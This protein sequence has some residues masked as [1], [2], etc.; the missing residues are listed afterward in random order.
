MSFYPQNF[1]L[2]FFSHRKLQQNKYTAT[3]ASAGG[4]QI[5]GGGGAPIN[6]KRRRRGAADQRSNFTFKLTQS[7]NEL[8][9]HRS[10]SS[11]RYGRPQQAASSPFRHHSERQLIRARY[12]S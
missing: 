1:L 6:K 10:V 9:D 5:I 8:Q 4:R 2:T 7:S 11:A 12:V 3:M